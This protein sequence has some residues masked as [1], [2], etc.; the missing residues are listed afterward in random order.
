MALAEA[1]TNKNRKKAAEAPPKATPTPSS[2]KDSPANPPRGWTTR[3]I[4][5]TIDDR[6][7]F[8]ETPTR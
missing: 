6:E 1:A 3:P 4:V 8:V 7:V 5:V 2:R